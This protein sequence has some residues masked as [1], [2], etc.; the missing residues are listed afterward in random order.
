MWEKIKKL[1]T[2]KEKTV[3]L[4]NEFKPAKKKRGRPK[5]S[6]SNAKA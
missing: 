2:K 3:I 1:F 4:N 6:K 5:K